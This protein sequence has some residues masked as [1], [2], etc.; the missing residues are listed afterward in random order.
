LHDGL[1]GP[2]QAIG[3]LAGLFMPRQGL[4]FRRWGRLVAG[5]A[6][7]CE[8]QKYEPTRAFPGEARPRENE[9][10]TASP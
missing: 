2:I 3:D 8:Q 4:I 1:V 10:G 9:D 5:A 7:G 6:A